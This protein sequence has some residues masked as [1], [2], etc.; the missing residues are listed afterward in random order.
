M[1]SRDITICFKNNDIK[2]FKDIYEYNV[3]TNNKIKIILEND[4][5]YCYP[6]AELEMIIVTTKL[7]TTGTWHITNDTILF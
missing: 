2:E 7:D 5:I 3:Y 4:K 6:I 1:Y